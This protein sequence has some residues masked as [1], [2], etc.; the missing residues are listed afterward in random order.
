MNLE[1]SIEQAAAS[2]IE[3]V[4][5]EVFELAQTY[6]PVS[7][8]N[9]KDSG[10]IT[11]EDARAVIRYEAPY[12]TEVHERPEGQGYKWL[13]R[14]MLEIDVEKRLQEAFKAQFKG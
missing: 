2:A 5:R 9:L 14:A 3:I 8:G 12:A 6:V 13:E 11:L 7:S 1:Q 4:A 10:S